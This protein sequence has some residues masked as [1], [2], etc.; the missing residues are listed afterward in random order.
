MW[1]LGN[2][3]IVLYS[4]FKGH[5]KD[6]GPRLLSVAADSVKEGQKPEL[7]A[8]VGSGWVLGRT[9]SPGGW[10]SPGRC[11]GKGGGSWSLGESGGIETSLSVQPSSHL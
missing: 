10:C 6:N 1:S 4:Y 5:C 7:A 11:P 3:L 2:D 9:C 8:S